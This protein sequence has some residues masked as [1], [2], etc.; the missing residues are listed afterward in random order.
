MKKFPPN[1]SKIENNLTEALTKE[2]EFVKDQLSTINK[3]DSHKNSIDLY[4]TATES[5]NRRDAED[6][7]SLKNWIEKLA[8]S[9]KYQGDIGEKILTRVLN[10]CEYKEKRW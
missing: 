1:S 8:G 4:R 9:S 7:N 3:V 6:I 5:K 10:S 2:R